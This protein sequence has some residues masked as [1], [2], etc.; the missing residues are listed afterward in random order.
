MIWGAPIW[1]N[2]L[3]VKITKLLVVF[4]SLVFIVTAIWII[5]SLAKLRLGIRKEE[6]GLL[7]YHKERKVLLSSFL[8]SGIVLV[9]FYMPQDV[10]PEKYSFDKISIEKITPSETIGRIEITA[11]EDLDEFSD[12]FRGYKCRRV[13]NSVYHISSD[14]KPIFI[15]LV[16]Y[17]SQSDRVYPLH[18]VITEDNLLRYSAANT[19]FF[20]KIKD[21]EHELENKIH[22][23]VQKHIKNQKAALR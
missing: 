2:E 21:P 12:L 14:S 7:N 8:L 23:Y 22:N 4:A 6:K 10:M 18:F 3:L 19:S 1:F 13:V 11:R 5:Y 15:D 9:L 16:A 17:E 20:Y